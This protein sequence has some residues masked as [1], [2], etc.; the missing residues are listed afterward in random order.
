M[1]GLLSEGSNNHFLERAIRLTIN[2]SQRLGIW[3]AGG[4]V[5]DPPEALLVRADPNPA[6]ERSDVPPGCWRL[7]FPVAS[8]AWAGVS[9]RQQSYA[10]VRSKH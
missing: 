3:G 2:N 10:G 4:K 1:D 6:P 5:A 7:H 8:P 9:C